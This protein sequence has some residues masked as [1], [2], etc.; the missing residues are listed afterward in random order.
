MTKLLTV[1]E[2][3]EKYSVHRA[4]IYRWIESGLPYEEVGPARRKRFNEQAVAQWNKEQQGK[5]AEEQ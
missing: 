4:T 1:K 5:E 2:L 3:A